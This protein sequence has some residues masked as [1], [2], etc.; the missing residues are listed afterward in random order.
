MKIFRVKSLSV[1]FILLRT[2]LLIMSMNQS[3]EDDAST[4]VLP[5]EIM[6]EIFKFVK[7]DSLKNSTLVCKK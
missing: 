2:E 5:N 1:N 7:A 4:E 6:L 3:N